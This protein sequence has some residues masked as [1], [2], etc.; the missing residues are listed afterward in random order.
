LGAVL[1]LARNTAT[2]IEFPKRT[3]NCSARD[4]DVETRGAWNRFPWKG[5]AI[6]PSLFDTAFDLDKSLAV[7]L[8]LSAPGIN[9]V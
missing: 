2:E 3:T 8:L 9:V 7:E 1:S 5:T 4:I 6:E